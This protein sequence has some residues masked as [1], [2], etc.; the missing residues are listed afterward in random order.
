[1][2]KIL[3]LLVPTY[4]IELFSL[5]SQIILNQKARTIQDLLRI[6]L[7]LTNCSTFYSPTPS[8][9]KRCQGERS[10]LPS[11]KPILELL[12]DPRR[13]SFLAR[14]RFL[15]IWLGNVIGKAFIIHIPL[16][17]TRY[18]ETILSFQVPN[19]SPN[20]KIKCNNGYVLVCYGLREKCFP[21]IRMK[22][23]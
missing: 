23:F 4:F 11:I 22:F 10:I 13:N 14:S 1:M 6:F 19:W 18:I 12:F 9:G 5:P 15:I 16:L 17:V 20:R 3:D 8:S 2:T 21:Y 7:N